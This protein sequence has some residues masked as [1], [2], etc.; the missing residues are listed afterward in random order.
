MQ[1]ECQRHVGFIKCCLLVG[2]HATWHQCVGLLVALSEGRVWPRSLRFTQRLSLE[3]VQE[4]AQQHGSRMCALQMRTPD[5]R[6]SM[7]ELTEA[8]ERRLVEM[9]VKSAGLGL[10]WR[11]LQGGGPKLIVCTKGARTI[12]SASRRSRASSLLEAWC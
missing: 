4:H 1:E 7:V 6:T 5:V 9:D 8:K 2:R 12:T 3:C 11:W 10:G